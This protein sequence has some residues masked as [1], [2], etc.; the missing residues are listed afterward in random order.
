MKRHQYMITIDEEVRVDEDIDENNSIST[1]YP[2]EVT[3]TRHGNSLEFHGKTLPSALK[4][5]MD[6][7]CLSEVLD[8]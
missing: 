4:R 6:H 2:F 1:L 5:A 8:A 7:I 3:V